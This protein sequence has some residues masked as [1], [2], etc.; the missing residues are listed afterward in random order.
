[1]R[2]RV[3]ASRLYVV[4]ILERFLDLIFENVTVKYTSSINQ[5]FSVNVMP[6]A[7][8]KTKGATTYC[9]FRF[10]SPPGSFYF[11][12]PFPSLV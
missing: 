8:I 6:V 11:S 4:Q 10:S 12:L 5:F 7:N 1:M 2:V 3:I 9:F